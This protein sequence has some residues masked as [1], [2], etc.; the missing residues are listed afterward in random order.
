MFFKK[1]AVENPIQANNEDKPIFILG[2]GALAQYFAAKLTILGHKALLLR[3][4]IAYKN[5]RSCSSSFPG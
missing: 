4:N 2:D 5:K 3:K 1:K